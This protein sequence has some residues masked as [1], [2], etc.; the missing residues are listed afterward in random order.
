MEQSKSR[1]IFRAFIMS[2]VLFSAFASGMEEEPL[3][4]DAFVEDAIQLEEI[5]VEG[6]N[7]PTAIW[8]GSRGYYDRN[9]QRKMALKAGGDCLKFTGCSTAILTVSGI[10][11]A[12]FPSLLASLIGSAFHHSGTT[13]LESFCLFWQIF[14]TPI[15]ATGASIGIIGG[16]IPGGRAFFRTIYS[17]LKS[18]NPFDP[19][20]EWTSLYKNDLKNEDFKMISISPEIIACAN[21]SSKL[22][23]KI[24]SIIQEACT[25]KEKESLF[26]NIRRTLF[27]ADREDYAILQRIKERLSRTCREEYAR[28]AYSLKRKLTQ[29]FPPEIIL[30]IFKFFPKNGEYHNLLLHMIPRREIYNGENVH[31]LTEKEVLILCKRI[32]RSIHKILN[33]YAEPI[34]YHI[35]TRLEHYG[36]ISFAPNEKYPIACQMEYF[37]ADQMPKEARK[38][39]YSERL[40]PIFY[41]PYH[42]DLARFYRFEDDPDYTDEYEKPSSGKIRNLLAMR[43]EVINQRAALRPFH[44][45]NNNNNNND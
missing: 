3:F 42:P 35:A 25:L 10:S 44:N 27:A 38:M 33:H 37:E 20:I 13:Y 26:W 14:L 6:E 16:T 5:I 31:Y 43:N 15:I 28:T 11:L 34:N 40:S 22:I 32:K 41:L 21:D 29:S 4:D 30:A 7:I 19:Q 18:E 2:S 17:Q 36:W 39:Y 8:D 24:P 23:W 12:L 45:E 9:A 1:S